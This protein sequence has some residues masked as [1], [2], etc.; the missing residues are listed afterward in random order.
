MDKAAQQAK[1]EAHV[2]A[3]AC[4]LEDKDECMACGS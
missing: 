2:A 3:I 4:S 1:V